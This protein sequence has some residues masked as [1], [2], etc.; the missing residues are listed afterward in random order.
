MF[1][2]YRYGL[3]TCHWLSCK[4]IPCRHFLGPLWSLSVTTHRLP[5]IL[6]GKYGT[7]LELSRTCLNSCESV[8]AFS[9]CI[10]PVKA[11]PHAV[12]DQSS[13]VWS[14]SGTSAKKQAHEHTSFPW[15]CIY[16]GMSHSAQEIFGKLHRVLLP[17]G[18]PPESGYCNLSVLLR[19]TLF[20]Q[21]SNLLITRALNIS[22]FLGLPIL[23]CAH[24]LESLWRSAVA[25]PMR[26]FNAV[27]MRP[28]SLSIFV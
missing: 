5:D 17:S 3:M 21:H 16:P 23:E 11:C 9:G 18:T 19:Q 8:S 4:E 14:L 25:A 10:E 12:T 13:P 28:S 20:R 7:L 15:K 24:M 1:R 22:S 27:Q 6:T 2:K 26:A